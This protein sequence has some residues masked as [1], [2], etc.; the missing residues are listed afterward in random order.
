[1]SENLEMFSEWSPE[2]TVMDWAIVK[3][4]LVAKAAEGNL[5]AITL[6]F[7]MAKLPAYQAACET[8]NA[9]RQEAATHAAVTPAAESATE[10]A[11]ETGASP[12]MPTHKSAA[13]SGECADDSAGIVAHRR[14]APNAAPNAARRA[15]PA[16]VHAPS[17]AD[18]AMATA[19]V[20]CANGL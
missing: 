9:W 20:E 2:M 17:A 8:A 19:S 14:A 7:R 4:A 6:I 10:P 1:M 15:V 5:Q 13:P 16:A 3:Q 12:P 11:T 18:L